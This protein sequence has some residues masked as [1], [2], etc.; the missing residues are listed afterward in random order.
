MEVDELAVQV[1]DLRNDGSGS[2]AARAQLRAL[3]TD[4]AWFELERRRAQLPDLSTAQ[5]AR[6]VADAGERA[7]VSLVK[8]LGDYHG[9]SR[10]DVWAAKFAIHETAVAAR[11]HNAA[12]ARPR[13]KTRP[14]EEV[15][16]RC[17]HSSR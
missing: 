9:Q 6:L 17:L 3:L 13:R 11:R 10:F 12:A 2:E 14:T 16:E 5:I 4:V 15:I 1:E 7:G 8:A